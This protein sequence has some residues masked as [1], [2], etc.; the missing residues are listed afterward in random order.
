MWCLCIEVHKHSIRKE[1]EINVINTR[2][3]MR[4]SYLSKELKISIII[5]TEISN[6]WRWKHVTG[7]I[8]TKESE[9]SYI[10]FVERKLRFKRAI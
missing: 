2:N 9:Q 10:R 7:T 1:K 4:L 5:K 3:T 6:S 8:V